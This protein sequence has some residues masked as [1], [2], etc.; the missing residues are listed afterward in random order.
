MDYS[1]VLYGPIY[2]TQG[3][4]AT[5]TVAGT[6]FTVNAKDLTSGL[7]LP[8]GGV[9]LETSR[10]MV[11]MRMADLTDA[12]LDPDTLDGADLDI[13]GNSWTVNAWKFMPSPF[14]QGD[15]EIYL[16]LEGPA[17]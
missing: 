11:S 10:P 15:G 16:M 14:G 17:G 5:I 8:T 2:R 3:V 4:T 12:G 1:K 9:D 6:P 13:N 7:Q